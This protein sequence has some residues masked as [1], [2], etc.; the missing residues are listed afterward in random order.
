MTVLDHK[1]DA[2]ESYLCRCKYVKT[3]DSEIEIRA[4][5]AWL[6]FFAN[7]RY[8]VCEILL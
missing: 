1:E 3:A 4:G 8:S 6:F 7:G 2:K 5:V